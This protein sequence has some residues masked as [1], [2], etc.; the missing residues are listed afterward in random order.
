M[1]LDGQ[2]TN[3]NIKKEFDDDLALKDA[4]HKSLMGR[5]SFMGINSQILLLVAGDMI[6]GYQKSRSNPTN[7][8][9]LEN[10]LNVNKK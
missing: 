5:I 4:L 8:P 1:E 9:V 3:G 2:K 7:P 10:D 6:S